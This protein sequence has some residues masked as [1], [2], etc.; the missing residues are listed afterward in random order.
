MSASRL[1]NRRRQYKSGPA[2]VGVLILSETLHA[3][4]V[5]QEWLHSPDFGYVTRPDDD[6]FLYRWMIKVKTARDT[7]KHTTQCGRGGGTWRAAARPVKS[8]T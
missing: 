6:M 3:K 4:E 2:A 1:R 5:L 8:R 7:I